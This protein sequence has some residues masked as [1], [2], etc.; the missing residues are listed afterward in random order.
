MRLEEEDDGKV[1][2]EDL[3]A[4]VLDVELDVGGGVGGR[5]HCNCEGSAKRVVS[6]N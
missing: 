4:G 3:V 2:G 1:D 5:L 6:R